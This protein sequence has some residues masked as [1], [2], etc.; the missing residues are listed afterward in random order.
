MR[1]IC[2]TSALA[3]LLALIAGAGRAQPGILLAPPVSAPIAARFVAHGTDWGPGHRGIDYVVG[4]GTAIR[5]AAAGR[6]EFA[7]RVAGVFAITVDHGNGISTTYSRLSDILVTEGAVVGAGTWIG[8]AGSSHGGSAGGLHFGVKQGTRYVDPESFLGPLRSDH[9]FH[10]APLRWRPL[11]TPTPELWDPLGAGEA[12]EPCRTYPS[13][14]SAPNDNVAVAIAG[15][16]SQTKGELSADMYEHGPEQIGYPSRRVY[17]FSYASTDGPRLHEPYARTATYRDIR[18]SATKLRSLLVDI[19]RRHPGAGVDLIAH[20]QGGIVARTL[21]SLVAETWDP[22][23]P[24]IEHLVTFSSPHTGAPL[25]A[26]L[27]ELRSS[28]GGDRLVDILRAWSRSGASVPDPHAVS[29][30]Q[31]K[32]DSVLMAAL[33]QEDLFLGT[34][35]LTL[36][37]ANDV[38][39]PADHSMIPGKTS[40]IVGPAGLNGHSGVLTSE[41]A[42]GIAHAFL[43]DADPSCRS[44]WDLWGPRVGRVVSWS[45]TRLDDVWRSVEHR[46]RGRLSVPGL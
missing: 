33:A 35:V 34:R 18:S 28:S 15:L 26:T 45:E 21:L 2:L 7:G 22:R 32:P 1:R 20:S 44:T 8:R 38:V 10:L 42:W 23:L 41:R 37:I 31:L 46:I 36:G 17:R 9:A 19:A 27:R 43:R 6:V 4:A 40:A 5:A 16:D 25:A 30:D 13:T 24:P 39:V 14:S 3:V 11:T 12:S 29:V